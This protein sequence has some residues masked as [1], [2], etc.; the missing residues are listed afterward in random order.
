MAVKTKIDPIARDIELIVSDSLSPAGQRKAVAA[1]AQNAINEADQTNRQVL[2]RIP[3]RTITVDGSAGARLDSVDPRRGSII[4]EWELVNDVLIWIGN[5]LRDR[6]P[7]VSGAFR[8][9]WTLLAD[10]VEVGA[11]AQTPIADIY[12][13]VNTVP[14]SRKIEIGKTKS[15]RDFVIQV[16]NRIAERTAKDAQSKFGNLAKIKSM[17][18]TLNSGY[19]LKQNQASR[20]FTSGKLRVS[21]HQRT[22]R[23]SGSAITYPAVIVTLR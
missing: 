8:E 17:F 23:V 12:T 20:S 7:R 16:P 2:G 15:G 11:E 1:F 18:I 14:Y 10:G 3:P 22:D 9:G 5:A 21:K 6:S 19:V 4:V 13:Y